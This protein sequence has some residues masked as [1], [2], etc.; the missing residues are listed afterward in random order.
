MNKI[1]AGIIVFIFF[2]FFA[3]ASDSLVDLV[4]SDYLRKL[5]SEKIIIETQTKDNVPI[6]LP[7]HKGLKEMVEASLSEIK[8]SNFVETLSLYEKPFFATKTAWTNE[9]KLALLNETLALSTL[10]GIEYFSKTRGKMRPLYNESVVIDN[11]E[12]RKILK[13]TML[14]SL[15]EEIRIYAKQK[16]TTF[17]ENIYQYNYYV[18]DDILTFVQRNLSPIRYGFIS[19]ADK[20]KLCSVVAIIDAGDYLLVYALSMADV[21]SISLFKKRMNESFSNRAKAIMK[22]FSNRADTAYKSVRKAP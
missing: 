2:P 21:T 8:P 1:T 18:K 10:K 4:H 17:G 16:D 5:I 9:E 11:P 15:P 14:S 22:W 13:D 7:N 19:V 20:N 12:N 3:I 6:L